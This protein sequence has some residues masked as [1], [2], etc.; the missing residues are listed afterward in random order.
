MGATVKVTNVGAE[1]YHGYDHGYE[2]VGLGLPPSVDVDPG[3]TVE[4]SVEKAEQLQRDHPDWF[5]VDGGK[6]G[7][8]KASADA[9]DVDES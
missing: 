8:A 7:K 9:E 6:R 1:E 4:V 5:K 3:D 2:P